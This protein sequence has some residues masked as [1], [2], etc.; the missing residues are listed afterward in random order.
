MT[1]FVL[2]VSMAIS[3]ASMDRTQM[4][5]DQRAFAPRGDPAV[6]TYTAFV[7]GKK[8]KAPAD[9]AFI[10][11]ALDR[12]VSAVEG[13]ALRERDPDAEV[14]SAAHA[15]RH[16]IRLLQPFAPATP[17]RITKRW[18]AFAQAAALIDELARELD[19]RGAGKALRAAVVRAADSIDYDDPLKWQ[20]DSL[21]LFFTLAA[22]ALTEMAGGGPGRIT[23]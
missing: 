15:V 10:I 2:L 7:E 1:S 11:A 6:D 23:N 19:P 13:L 14:L 22:R 12:L 21:E 4:S 17:E 3:L 9:Q 16:E 18:K 8:L 20:P 5:G